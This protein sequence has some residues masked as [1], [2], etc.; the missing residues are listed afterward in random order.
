MILWTLQKLLNLSQ[1]KYNNENIDE[2]IQSYSEPLPN[3][4]LIKLQERN[5]QDEE[6]EP[7]NELIVKTLTTKN[8]NEAFTH[9]DKLLTIMEECDPNGE[10]ISQVGRATEKDGKL[11][12]SLS[13]KE[14]ED[15]NSTIFR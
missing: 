2:L 4:D 15:Y 1:Q 12:S 14:I 8:M 13:R 6:E 5:I 9:L 11:Q 7:D 10:L 3:E